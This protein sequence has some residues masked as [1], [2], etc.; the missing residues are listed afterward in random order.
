MHRPRERFFEGSSLVAMR[1]FQ[2]ARWI[3]VEGET[4]GVKK[5]RYDLDQQREPFGAKSLS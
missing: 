5:W 4:A 3:P 1:H 2:A